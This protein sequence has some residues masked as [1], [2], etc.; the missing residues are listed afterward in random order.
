MNLFYFILFYFLPELK[1]ITVLKISLSQQNLVILFKMWFLWNVVLASFFLVLLQNM[2][3]ALE[4]PNT[5]YMTKW[6][7]ERPWGREKE[8]EVWVEA[9]ALSCELAGRVTSG[10]VL[11]VCFLSISGEEGGSSV[12]SLCED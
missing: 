10:K 2:A 1:I 3:R 5:Y 6:I 8:Q 4:K 11:I 12:S 7:V 9:L